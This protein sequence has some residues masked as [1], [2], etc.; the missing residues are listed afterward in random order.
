MGNRDQSRGSQ[1]DQSGVG[2]PQ[3][4]PVAIQEALNRPAPRVL[5]VEGKI[6]LEIEISDQ[7]QRDHR[8]R[9]RDKVEPVG[10]LPGWHLRFCRR[11]AHR[12]AASARFIPGH[13]SPAG[14]SP[15]SYWL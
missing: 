14:L 2:A 9:D 12:G 13:V 1:L 6:G 15:L 3:R 4:Y 11:Q 8:D 7:S 5:I 10:H